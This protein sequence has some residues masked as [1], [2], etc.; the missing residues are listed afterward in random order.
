MSHDRRLAINAALR[1]W[2]DE[3][4][5]LVDLIGV[6]RVAK[7]R[8]VADRAMAASY[9]NGEQ[10]GRANHQSEIAYDAEQLER[11]YMKGVSG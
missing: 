11:K 3:L 1:D 7:V 5:K 10:A 6:V 9:H 2:I 8:R 4:S